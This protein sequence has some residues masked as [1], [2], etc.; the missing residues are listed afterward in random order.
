[1]PRVPA[2]APGQVGPAAPIEAKF[3]APDAGPGIGQGLANFGEAISQAVTVQDRLNAENDD[4]QAR[5]LAI[6]AQKRFAPLSSQFTQLQGGNAR[7]AQ[8][9]TLA[10]LAKARDEVLKSAANPRQKRFLDA[11]LTTLYQGHVDKVSGHAVREQQ[12]ERTA[13]FK[14]QVSMYAEQAAGTTDVDERFRLTEMGKQ[15]ISEY[16]DFQGIKDPTARAFETQRFTDGIHRD[17]MDRMLAQADPD[18]EMVQTYLEAHDDEILAGTREAILK[19]LQA[20]MQAREAD[21]D[22]MR[23]TSGAEKP[24][25]APAGVMGAVGM[26][27]LSM[28]Q[29]PVTGK[30][31]YSNEV[32]SYLK[33]QGIPEHVAAGA[34][35]GV[36]AESASNGAARNPSSGAFGIG[37]WLGPRKR[38][39]FKRYG[40]NPTL[41]QQLEFLAYELKGGDH[42]GAAVLGAKSKEEAL[43]RYITKFMRPAAGGETK[44]DLER[45]LAALGGGAIQTTADGHAAEQPRQWD[46]DQTY[47][48]I[49]ALADKEGW[50]FERRE[51]VKRR[52]DQVI[53]RDEDLLGRQRRAAESEVAQIIAGLPNGLTSLNQIPRHLRETMDPVKLAQL[54]GDIRDRE[55][56][57]SEK[58]RSE[59]QQNQATRLEWMRRFEPDKFRAINPLD[60]QGKLSPEQFRSMLGNHLEANQAKPFDP[61]DVRGGI[62]GEIAFQEKHGGLNLND[63]KKVDV[64]DFME[65]QLRAIQ[66]NKGRLEKSD[67]TSAWQTA[68]RQM[69]TGTGFFGGQKTTPAYEIMTDVPS[70]VEADIRR[71]WKGGRPPTKGE[72]VSVWM[73]ML[74]QKK[75]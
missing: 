64:Y 1:M 22:F 2:Y 33:G 69:P 72:I 52:A 48:K 20:P 68:M 10:E 42:G 13:T 59:A 58:A 44:G 50:S 62:T 36:H 45:G 18:V 16:L 39:L 56:A 26:Q 24:Q 43:E 61:T 12:V 23:A 38:E 32:Y 47:D 25:S 14:G 15:A 5:Q 49:D 31:G 75:R 21:T 53:A 51:R 74:R 28:I 11:Q 46:K 41:T 27:A 4:T 37:Q 6:E 73:E 9:Q 7:T 67:Y 71:S 8:Q 70:D 19:D 35:A 63:D 54:G 65:A 55:R 66:K 3:R 30:T 60:Y 17:V 57:A 29:M 34:A 40:P